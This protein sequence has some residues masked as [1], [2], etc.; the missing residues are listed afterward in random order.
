M[1][2][3]DLN[4]T[5]L[6]YSRFNTF[7]KVIKRCER[8][9][10]SVTVAMDFPETA[11]IAL[12]QERIIKLVDNLDIEINLVRRDENFGLVKS[13]LTSIDEA[14]QRDDHFVL[15]EDDCLPFDS[16]FSY[17][18]ESLEKHKDNKNITS[19]CGT[20]TRCPFNPWGWGSWK[21]KWE[22]QKIP[23]EEIL[24]IKKIDE[25]L[26]NFLK[27]NKVE[28]SVWSL[29]WL[30]NQYKNNSSAVFPNK[31]LIKNI[32]LDNSGVHSPGKGYTKW[33]L[34]QIVKN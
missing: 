1:K 26:K 20:I 5:V 9:L 30:A 25:S 23:V 19:V 34:S 10:K 14:L 6:A 24:S 29:N 17:M 15:L 3:I 12:Q 22:Y 31:N 7:E 16:F 27:N 18:N 21:N 8:D 32:G 28:E 4:V 33:L 2:K 13:V 11:E